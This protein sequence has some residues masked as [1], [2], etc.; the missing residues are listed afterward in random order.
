[1]RSQ[2]SRGVPEWSRGKDIHMGSCHTVAEKVRGHIGIVPGS[3]RKVPEDS[4][5]VRKSGKCSTT[6]NTAAWAVGGRPN[7]NGPRA[8][9][10]PRPMRMGEGKP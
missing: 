3:F 8:P 10:P 9:A 1:M 2:M 6:S 7:L 5:G 4:G